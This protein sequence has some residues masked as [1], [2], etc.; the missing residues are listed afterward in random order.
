MGNYHKLY[1]ITILQEQIF[2]L[3]AVKENNLGF[4]FYKIGNALKSTSL[5]DLLKSLKVQSNPLP[6]HT[7]CSPIWMQEGRTDCSG[8]VSIDFLYSGG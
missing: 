3:H 6:V 2:M 1:E 7:I 5:Y 8:E 4:P